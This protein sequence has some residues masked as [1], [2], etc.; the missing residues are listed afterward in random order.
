LYIAQ[1]AQPRRPTLRLV[2]AKNRFDLRH[3]ES[4]SSQKVA[5]FIPPNTA[6]NKL[7]PPQGKKLPSFSFNHP[8]SYFIVVKSTKLAA[9]TF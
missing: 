3:G 6:P 4:S 2:V 9:P 1:A 8:S 7:S 5:G